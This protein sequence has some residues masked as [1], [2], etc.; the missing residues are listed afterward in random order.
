MKDIHCGR[1]HASQILAIFNEAIANSTALWD[2]EPRTMSSMDAWFDAKERGGYP[3]VGVVDDDDRL[4]AFGSYGS[5]R[6]WPAYKYT[7]EH[8]LYV[9]KGSRR[10]GLGRHVLTRLVAEAQVQA[11][12]TLI[13][14]IECGNTASVELHKSLGF[15]MAGEIRDAGFKFGKW[16]NLA[17]YQ[18]LLSG[19]A[20]PVD[21]NAR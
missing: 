13:G 1:H 19:P 5:F 14:G 10:Q 9:E 12:R 4:L 11:Y 21:G 6:A 8:S 3:V 7:V 16:M 18:L 17:F 20:N 2:Y 15:E